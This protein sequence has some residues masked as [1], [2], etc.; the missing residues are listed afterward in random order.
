[1][2]DV[3]PILHGERTI[4]SHHE[5]HGDVIISAID[6]RVPKSITQVERLAFSTFLQV[7]ANLGGTLHVKN[8]SLSFI[9]LYQLREDLL[10]IAFSS[11]FFSNR[12]VPEPV[13]RLSWIYDS[14][15]NEG[16]ALV[17]CCEIQRHFSNESHQIIPWDLF[18]FWESRF[19]QLSY[20]VFSIGCCYLFGIHCLKSI[21]ARWACAICWFLG[22]LYNQLSLRKCAPVCLKW[23]GIFD[24]MHCSGC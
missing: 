7:I 11:Q 3:I 13:E 14:K 6:I 18:V 9:L 5:G 12:E 16:F 24:L 4:V 10:T 17:V 22:M 15:A 21:P 19:T 8:T 1:M 2:D 20:L 23:N